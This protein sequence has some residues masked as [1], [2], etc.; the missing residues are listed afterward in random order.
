M[1]PLALM[2]VC[3]AAVGM[4]NGRMAEKLRHH[5]YRRHL[6]PARG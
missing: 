2:A 5:E 3:G 6:P 4:M 1:I